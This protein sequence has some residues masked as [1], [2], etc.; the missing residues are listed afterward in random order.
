MLDNTNE[1]RLKTF[2]FFTTILLVMTLVL[3]GFILL[4]KQNW[5]YRLAYNVEEVMKT[6][7]PLDFPEKFAV[8]KPVKINSGIATS[9]NLYEIVD[10]KSNRVTNYALITRVTTYYGPQAAVFFYDDVKGVTF[11]GFACLHSRIMK[12]FDNKDSDLVIKFWKQTAEKVF[13]DSIA[14]KGAGNE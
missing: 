4:G 13:K 3:T 9:S 6:S 10:L 12:Q 8:G 11:E 7:R 14:E 1:T 2:A 5:N